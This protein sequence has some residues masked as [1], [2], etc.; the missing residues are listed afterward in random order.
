MATKKITP[1]NPD[2]KT[3]A[4]ADDKTASRKT[5]TSHVRFR[6]TVRSYKVGH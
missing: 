3:D 4:K 1:K 2:T 6:K 5:A